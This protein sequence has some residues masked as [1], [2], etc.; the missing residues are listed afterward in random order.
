M[1]SDRA[2]IALHPRLRPWQE[3]LSSISIRKATA[4]GIFAALNDLLEG[5]P[6]LSPTRL[7]LST[8]CVR[9]GRSSDA[10]PED[11]HR[12]NGILKG[13]RPWRKGPFR[14]F[15]IDIETEWR[16]DWKWQR[17]QPAVSPLTGR[18]VL[19]VGSSSGY[20]M[21]RMLPDDPELVVG[22]EPFPAYYHQFLLLQSFVRSE[23]L[24][25]LPLSFEELPEMKGFF[26]T[27]FLMGVLYHARHPLSVLAGIRGLMT[28]GGELVLENLVLE[29]SA[30][31]LLRPPGRYAKMRNVYTI[32]S[33]PRLKK[34][35]ESSG[36]GN[37]RC[38]DISRTLP[39]EQRR[40][41]WM[42]FESLSDF[43]APNDPSRTVEGHPAPVRAVI[44][45]EAV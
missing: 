5:L 31:T 22:I 28:D 2:G 40:T 7:S 33:V 45:G 20:Y 27:V 37:L 30:A 44:I 32:P 13:L 3:T 8:D 12:L 39:A 21:F 19:D 11:R 6:S 26:D 41:D 4:P 42:P 15:G 38:V 16:S 23:K 17:V 10:A 34:W 25:C 24:C 29:D 36:F 35:L 18:R 14:V 9:I 1:Q 43:L